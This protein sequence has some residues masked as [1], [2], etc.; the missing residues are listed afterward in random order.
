MV[1]ALTE[2]QQ[3]AFDCVQV[4]TKNQRQ[5]RVPVLKEEDRQAWLEG[6]KALKWR[7]AR[8]PDRVVSHASYLINLASPVKQ[9][10][11]AS[12]ALFQHELERC[13]ALSIPLCVVHPGAHLGT[14]PER[15]DPMKHGGEFSSD[16][17]RGMMRLAQALDHIHAQ[18]PGLRVVTCLETT[19]GAGTTLGHTFEQLAFM[20]DAV[21]QPERVA[22]CLDTCHVTAAGYDMTT[23]GKAE[24]VIQRFDSI[25][26][27][28]RLRALHMNDSVFPVGSRRDRHAH[29]GAGLCGKS[30][31]AAILRLPAL[32]RV[33]KILETPKGNGPKGVPW[34]V[35]NVRRLKRLARV[36][37]GSR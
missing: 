17:E 33:P 19:A 18:L 27:L 16:E 12:V 21:R 25:G 7:S 11:D 20:R 10:W 13:E 5:W 3:L 35:I 1:N 9:T 6:L 4:F 30:C 32:Q 2:A 28:K 23:P 37:A 34:D 22:F 26:G 24:Q 36:P 8:G 29:I 31:F 14:A 15:R